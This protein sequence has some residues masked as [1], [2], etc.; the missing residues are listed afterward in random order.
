[1]FSCSNS[2]RLIVAWSQ[3]N[4][5]HWLTCIETKLMKPNLDCLAGHPSYCGQEYL[6]LQLSSNAR[7]CLDVLST[8]Y[9]KSSVSM[10]A[11]GDLALVDVYYSNLLINFT[12][13]QRHFLWLQQ[14]SLYFV[15]V[16]PDSTIPIARKA[17]DSGKSLVVA[18]SSHPFSKHKLSNWNLQLYIHI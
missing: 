17:R 4:T 15:S 11:H 18:F 7:F 8:G 5:D 6:C 13:M 1:M 12:A 2:L 9:I 10:V 3:R 16:S 14:L